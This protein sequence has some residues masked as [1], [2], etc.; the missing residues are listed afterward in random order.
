MAHT[1]RLV[2]ASDSLGV[3][4]AVDSVTVAGCPLEVQALSILGTVGD[5]EVADRPAIGM[6]GLH[7]TGMR[8]ALSDSL[9]LLMRW[10]GQMTGARC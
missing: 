1:V 4:G 3:E 10:L 6:M 2:C 8:V 9:M 5:H 7:L